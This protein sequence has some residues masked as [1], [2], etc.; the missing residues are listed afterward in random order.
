MTEASILFPNL[1]ITLPRVGQ[2]INLF[3]FRIAYYGIT[4]ALGMCCGVCLVLHV[5]KKTGQNADMYFDLSLI[6]LVCAVVGARI[7]Y[8]V[9]SWEDYRNNPL[10]ILNIRGGGLAI[11]GGVIAGALSVW[12]FSRV[13]HLDF[14]LLADTFAPGLVL[15]QAIG[16]WGNFFNREVFGGYTDNLVA[17]ALP[18]M[19]VRQDEIT[20]KMLDHLYMVDNVEFIQVHPTFLYESVWNLAL[21][22]FLLWF[23]G[24]RHFHGEVFLY[25]LMGYGLGRAWIEGVRTDRLLIPGTSLPVS[26]MLS[27][28]LAASAATAVVVWKKR[29][30]ERKE[31]EQKRALKD[32]D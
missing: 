16:R 27:L 5:A 32:R 19:A 9:F 8:V 18:R 17:M 28:V 26:Q 10:E 24:R 7:Y 30:K 22:C 13:K 11:Y 14:G 6:T 2:Y 12:I 21:L 20:Q 31:D 4:M 23:A 25:Y 1:G 29:R 3:G 15:G